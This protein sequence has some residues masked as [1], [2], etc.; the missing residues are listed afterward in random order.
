M[1]PRRAEFE[2]VKWCP[3]SQ[4][5]TIDD[6]QLDIFKANQNIG[7]T[8]RERERGGRFDLSSWEILEFDQNK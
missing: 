4:I 2:L 3:Y 7:K 6:T 8:E 1:A 5:D